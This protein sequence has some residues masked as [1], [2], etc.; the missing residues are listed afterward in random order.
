MFRHK[1]VIELI[2][3]DRIWVLSAES[4]DDRQIWFGRLCNLIKKEGKNMSPKM[5]CF[6]LNPVYD[7]YLS[8]YD[9]KT[10]TFTQRYYALTRNHFYYFDSAEQCEAAKSTAWFDKAKYNIGISKYVEGFLPLNSP[11]FELCNADQCKIFNKTHLFE[12]D[13]SFD[14]VKFS[15][16]H[17]SEMEEWQN[18]FVKLELMEPE[19]DDSKDNG[20]QLTTQDA[21]SQDILNNLKAN[22]NGK[23]K[24]KMQKKP[25]HSSSNSIN[26]SMVTHFPGF[27]KKDLK[28][29]PKMPVI[30]DEAEMK[31]DED[32]KDGYE[33]TQL[34]KPQPRRKTTNKSKIVEE[35]EKK[36]NDI[37]TS[38]RNRHNSKKD[39]R[40]RAVTSNAK[41]LNKPKKKKINKQSQSYKTKPNFG[42]AGNAG[43][44]DPF[45]RSK[46]ERSVYQRER[47]KSRSLN[48]AM[49]N[50]MMFG[51]HSHR[52]S[53]GGGTA[54]TM[55][56]SPGF[57]LA[58]VGSLGSHTVDNFN[59]NHTNH[60]N[61]A[62]SGLGAQLQ[63]HGHGNNLN[64]NHN[65]QGGNQWHTGMGNMGPN[66]LAT[67][68]NPAKNMHYLPGPRHADA[69]GFDFK[70]LKG[71]SFMS[72]HS[73]AVNM[74]GMAYTPHVRSAVG[75]IASVGSTGYD[76]R[77][78]QPTDFYT[79]NR[80][81]PMISPT[82]SRHGSFDLS[83]QNNV[84]STRHRDASLL[85]VTYATNTRRSVS[86]SYNTDQDDDAIS[87]TSVN[88]MHITQQ[89]SDKL[90][91][92]KSMLAVEADEGIV[93]ELLE[94][95]FVS[96]EA[97]VKA[98]IA[99]N[100]RSTDEAS[101]WLFNN[102]NDNDIKQDMD[103]QSSRKQSMTNMTTMTG[104]T[105][106]P[107]NVASGGSDAEDYQDQTESFSNMSA[108]MKGVFE[109]Q[110]IDFK[111]REKQNELDE[112]ERIKISE[113][114]QAS[115]RG[116]AY[117][118]KQCWME[119]I[120]EYTIALNEIDADDEIT[121]PAAYTYYAF[122]A[123]CY[124]RLGQLNKAE[125][126]TESWMELRWDRSDFEFI[127]G[128]DIGSKVYIDM[129]QY[130]QA[131]KLV[132]RALSINPKKVNLQK[133][134]KKL[135]VLLKKELNEIA[136]DIDR[137]HLEYDG[138]EIRYGQDE[139]EDA[140]SNHSTTGSQGFVASTIIFKKELH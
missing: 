61:A 98:A 94:L 26:L 12:V 83:M 38:P 18:A 57:A 41:K 126:D 106:Q 91:R 132:L 37:N 4:K 138:D 112:E 23:N 110:S 133:R 22:N 102:L 5:N 80:P 28:K 20:N 140:E 137:N 1:N 50:D 92:M 21:F 119:A 104:Y 9:D 134:L 68:Y 64:A 31:Q 45:R 55:N 76:D 33:E 128:C 42:G 65:H 56:Q 7:N 115:M 103:G 82:P 114:T 13:T 77:Y 52:K 93:A 67:S 125:Q 116:D 139:K 97:C 17:K 84:A 100:N 63:I 30:S 129:K 39:K 73:T 117:F 15:S 127:K 10:N 36:S 130:A 49:F 108:L 131:K 71:D 75:S 43:K 59:L 66:S 78:M 25:S 79:S 35:E 86:K 90:N 87:M 96:K 60:T 109:Y 122:R 40:S 32:M 120:K 29:K 44:V 74:N 8:Q 34:P 124:R 16:A 107:E 62:S 89:N 85:S 70:Q 105:T 48:E 121:H 72:T 19:Y 11:N 14:K 69:M 58:G 101:Q 54:L 6:R 111:Q 113:L 46:T 81:I 95:G 47:G 24:R 3:P 2:T 123:E 53:N 27:I 136:D 51:S 88:D 118:D 99:V 135:R